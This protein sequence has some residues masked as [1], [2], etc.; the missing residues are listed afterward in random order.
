[1]GRRYFCALLIDP[2]AQ[3]FHELHLD[4]PKETPVPQR[5]RPGLCRGGRRHR[6]HRV[7]PA[8]R[9][10]RAGQIAIAGSAL[11]HQLQ[12]DQAHD[13][14][15]GDVLAALIASEGKD[16]DKEKEIRA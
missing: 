10:R 7:D 14:L 1:M 9:G 13:A 12:A 11:K 2:Q 6:V 8:Q 5:S 3:Y 4:D 16:V 15:R